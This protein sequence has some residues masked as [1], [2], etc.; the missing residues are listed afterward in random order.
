MNAPDIVAGPSLIKRA[1]QRDPLAARTLIDETGPVVY[2]FIY[3]RVGGDQ[4]AAEDLL[5][6]TYLQAIRSADGFRGDSALE[7]WLCT[8]AKRQIAAHYKAE[9][10]RWMLRS[11][12]QLIEG[13]A[14][15]ETFELESALMEGDAVITA[16]GRLTVAHRQVLVLKYMDG[17]STEEVAKELGRTST[18]VQSLLQ[19]ARGALRRELEGS[20]DE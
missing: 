7:T 5:Q 9:R 19:R 6:S 1:A 3:A 20:E 10:R 11:K 8:I 14:E 17:L 18:Q 2:G 16:L 12:L 13:E 4:Q 15:E